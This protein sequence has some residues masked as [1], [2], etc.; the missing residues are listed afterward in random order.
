MKGT[1]KNKITLTMPETIL[2]IVVHELTL[3]DFGRS[4]RAV[5]RALWKGIIT[6][7]EFIRTMQITLDR[8]FE[9][10][11]REGALTVGITP[12]ERTAEE[13]RARLELLLISL[14][15]LAGFA[16]FIVKNQQP[17]GKQS[18]VFNRAKLW[19]NRYNEVRNLAIQMSGADKKLIWNVGPTE[20]CIDCVRLN[21][22]VKRASQWK[23]ANIAPQSH[24]L[25]CFGS[26]CQCE[27]VPTDKPLSKGPLPKL[28]GP[29]G[30]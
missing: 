25:N 10:A 12:D 8:G 3:A 28:V 30:R 18:T 7:A 16:A 22:K 23:A 24:L 2:D 26:H 4:V 11:W 20:H 9:Q 6:S 13:D 1:T 17:V 29:N 19:I 14:N 27:T 15:S 21:G 5:V